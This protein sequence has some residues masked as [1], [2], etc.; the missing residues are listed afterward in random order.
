MEL[1]RTITRLD[2]RAK[3]QDEVTCTYCIRRD[4]LTLHTYGSDDREHPE[5]ASQTIQFDLQGATRLKELIQ[6]AFPSL[7]R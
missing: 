5:I 7:R 6:E 1:I 2:K 4:K 3:P